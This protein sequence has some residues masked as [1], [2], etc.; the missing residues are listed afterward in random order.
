MTASDANRPFKRKRDIVVDNERVQTDKQ[1]AKPF[2]LLRRGQGARQG[3]SR[4]APCG[5]AR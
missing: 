3:H 5:V 2:G 1:I 4:M